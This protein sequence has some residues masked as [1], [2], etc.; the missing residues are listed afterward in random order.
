MNTEV[1]VLAPAQRECGT[2]DRWG[3]IRAAP[4]K[5]VE[6]TRGDNFIKV[7]LYEVDGLFYFGYQ[8]KVGKTLRQKAANIHGRSFGTK[9]LARICGCAEVEVTCNSNK[10][11]RKLFTEFKKI[12]G[13]QLE[14]FPEEG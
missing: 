6:E 4:V 5:V 10:N 7:L 1:S 13:A 14:L 2:C 12:A 8:I 9:E 3:N 11:T